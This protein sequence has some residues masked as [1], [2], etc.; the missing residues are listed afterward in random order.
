M[1]IARSPSIVPGLVV[2]ALKGP[3]SLAT[4]FGLQ[5]AMLDPAID[6]VIID[7][8]GVTHLDSAGLGVLL[9]Q[10]THSQRAAKKF[11]LAAISP[12]VLNILRITHTDRVLPIFA[13]VAD[14]EKSLS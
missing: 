10:G 3:F 8:S 2:L 5:S 7:M 12:K 13:T 9:G 6:G 4:I 11:A 1:E 14:A